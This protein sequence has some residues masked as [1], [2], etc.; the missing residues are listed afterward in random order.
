MRLPNRLNRLLQFFVSP[1]AVPLF[2][3]LLALL[4]YAP[5]LADLGFY[6]DD[7]PKLWISQRFGAQGL[8]DFFSYD[9]PLWGVLYQLTTPIFGTHALA[10]HIFALVL[11]WGC[12]LLV[13]MLLRRLWPGREQLAAAAAAF[14]LVY[15]GFSQQY[16]AL[17]FSH[18]Y[19]VLGA[20]LLSLYLML[21]AVQ[22][23]RR[24]LAWTLAA[25]AASALNLFTT[26]YFFFPDLLRPL[27]LWI[28][29][30][31]GLPWRRR[32]GKTV[33][34]WLPYLLLFGAALYW[35]VFIQGFLRYEPTLAEQLLSAP[36]AALP[37]LLARAVR[38]LWITTGGA[39]QRAL[40][41]LLTLAGQ[42][43]ATRLGFIALGLL[44]AGLSALFFWRF[45]RPEK[46]ALRAAWQPLA[47]AL[48]SLALA[49]GSFWAVDLP[50]MVVFAADRF[51]MPF[52]FGAGLLLA[53]LIGLLPFGKLGRGLSYGLLLGL[54][55]GMQF[56]N[57]QEY[58]RDWVFQ[59]NFFWQMSWRIPALREGTTLLINESDMP[60]Y[61]DNSLTAPLNWLY[62]PDST[63]R[64]MKYWLAWPTMRL[65]VEIPA[66]SPG[67]PI[68]VDYRAAV[69]DGSTDQLLVV[70]YNPPACLRVLDPEIDRYAG[71]I[72]DRLRQALPLSRLDL[73]QLDAPPARPL[74][75]LYGGEPPRRWCYYFEHADLAR[76][77][78]D[79]QRAAEAGDQALAEGLHPEDAYEYFVLVEAYAHL[80]RWDQAI[81][82][83]RAALAQNEYT[84]AP[85]CVLWQRIQRQT[86][87]TPDRAV[88][89]NEIIPGLTCP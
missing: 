65:G 8:A 9:R 87:D 18:Y 33:L 81:A 49:G 60:H 76:Q 46:P 89:L 64:Q 80:G 75:A 62:D 88:A 26:E 79:W 86:P 17:V 27:L 30:A 13:W 23:Q 42:E 84:N 11:R 48:V 56:V 10:W 5:R 69:F 83:T 54:A 72:P 38:D 3:F 63:S 7:F 39:W 36:G 28:A 44:A 57:A 71:I 74:P 73:I 77:R 35:R 45:A 19:L 6:W 22:L 37:E 12:A 51:T 29:L 50:I 66:L 47:I 34:A 70:L 24:R 21:R 78:G 82:L 58:R 67:L 4:A 25:L 61:T 14:H 32:L 40:L 16:V 20:Y 43:R 85:L 15:P 1:A 41:A 53:V 52:M 59:Q 68:Q 31:D 2:L 55:V